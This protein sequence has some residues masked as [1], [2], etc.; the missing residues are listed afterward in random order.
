MPRQKIEE[1]KRVKGTLVW[2]DTKKRICCICDEPFY[3]MGNNPEPLGKSDEDRCCDPCNYAEV[4]PARLQRMGF[5][6]KQA[7]AV[8]KAASQPIPQALRQQL[9]GGK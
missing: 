9:K 2:G 5:G 1:G 4:I 7:E 8:G 6:R 3:G